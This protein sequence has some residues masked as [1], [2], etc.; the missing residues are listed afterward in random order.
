M[1]V[2]SAPCPCPDHPVLCEAAVA[3]QEGDRCVVCVTGM[4]MVSW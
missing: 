1:I 3:Y 4:V 2:R